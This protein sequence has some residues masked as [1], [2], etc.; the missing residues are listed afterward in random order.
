M[1]TKFWELENLKRGEGCLAKAAIDEPIFV[2]R[3]QDK[4]APALVRAWAALA[5][6][7]GCSPDKTNEAVMLACSMEAWRT[8]KFP[9]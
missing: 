1:A 2:L 6:E 3:G 4:L 8:R 7:H 9:D 5:R